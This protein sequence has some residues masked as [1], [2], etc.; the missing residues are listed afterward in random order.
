MFALDMIGL[1]AK[2][3]ELKIPCLKDVNFIIDSLNKYK[4]V[5]NELPL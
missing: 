2:K 3:F 5:I 4:D 1:A